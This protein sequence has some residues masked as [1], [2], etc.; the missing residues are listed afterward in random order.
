MSTAAELQKLNTQYHELYNSF[1]TLLLATTQDGIP[2]MSYAPFVRDAE[3]VFYIYISELA[4][5]TANLIANP[6]A[7]VLFIQDEAQS[8]NLFARARIS[9]SCT[10]REIAKTDPLYNQQLLTMHTSFGEIIQ[11]LSG[12]NDFHMFALQP[13]QGRYV[14]GFGRAYHID[15]R[16]NCLTD[17]I[18]GA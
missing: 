8:A 3:G 4:Q 7:S 17:N 15:I 6:Q 11:L 9:L 5:H 2:E 1:K 13:I 14:A 12:L 18:R 10:A 16:K